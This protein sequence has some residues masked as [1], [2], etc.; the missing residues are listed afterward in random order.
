MAAGSDEIVSG[1][2]AAVVLDRKRIG[3]AHFES[4]ICGDKA[5]D[6]GGDASAIERGRHALTK[7]THDQ[8]P[9]NKNG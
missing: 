7:K 6:D 2:V 3:A 1:R 8:F 9:Q 4:H 5:G